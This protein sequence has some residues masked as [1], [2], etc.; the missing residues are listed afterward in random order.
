MDIDQLLEEM[1][2]TEQP[3]LL[4]NYHIDIES[5]EEDGSWHGK[6][7]WEREDTTLPILAVSNSNTGDANKYV[8]IT[9]ADNRNAFFEA[10]RLAFPSS[11]EPVDTACIYLELREAKR[12]DYLLAELMKEDE[13]L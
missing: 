11:S 10:C 6:V 12:Q 13:S 2:S 8:N 5:E 1:Y 4:A 3:E 7:W 9:G